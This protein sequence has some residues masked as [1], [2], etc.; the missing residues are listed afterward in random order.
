[1]ENETKISHSMKWLRAISERALVE[2]VAFVQ[3]EW[4]IQA[5]IILGP[6]GIL[7]I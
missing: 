3:C 1:M 4:R 7:F 6:V 2:V 5:L